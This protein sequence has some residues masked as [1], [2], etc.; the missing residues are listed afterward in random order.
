M[1]SSPLKHH[2][3]GEIGDLVEMNLAQV[4]Q[5]FFKLPPLSNIMGKGLGNVQRVILNNLSPSSEET[6]EE[7]C[8]LVYDYS[9]WEDL[10]YDIP[11]K[12]QYESVCRAVRTLLDRGLIERKKFPN[13]GKKIVGDSSY[14]YA[15]RLLSDDE[16]E[17]DEIVK[18]AK[19]EIKFERKWTL[20]RLIREKA[21]TRF[22]KGEDPELIDE[23]YFE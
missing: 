11:T 7:L 19:K 12:S 4:G 6:I 17:Y 23:N 3:S 22:D 15:I 2:G 13:Y 5:Q 10:D 8:W 18:K 16:W 1:V 14:F 21:K 20:R 9:N